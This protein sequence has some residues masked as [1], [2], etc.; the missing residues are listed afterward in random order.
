MINNTDF[1]EFLAAFG[2]GYRTMINSK[3]DAVFT[4][5][6]FCRELLCKISKNE[7]KVNCVNGECNWERED[8]AF[9]ALY[10][11]K[12]RRSLKPIAKFL[13]LETNRDEEKFKNFLQE[14]VMNYP[15]EK[16]LKNFKEYLPDTNLEMQLTSRIN[17]NQRRLKRMTNQMM[18]L[19][20]IETL[21]QAMRFKFQIKQ[22]LIQTK[23]IL[24]SC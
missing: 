13:V 10:R 2:D 20:Y 3:T 11:N 21:I 19:L 14:Y 23:A 5:P 17:G 15:K 18:I 24:Y 4:K 16:L 12:D 1:S 9:S 7:S 22:Q 8:S 6:L